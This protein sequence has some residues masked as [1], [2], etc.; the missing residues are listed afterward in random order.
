MSD[1]PSLMGVAWGGCAI[2]STFVAMRL[3]SRVIISRSM[4]WDDILVCVGAALNIVSVCLCTLAV[5][6]GLGR[7]ISSLSDHE[8]SMTLYYSTVLQP[9][10]VFSYC[11]PK[12][13]VVILI[14]KVMMLDRR[15]TYQL[16]ALI[17]LLFVTS[18]LA[19]LFLFV[20][21]DP[22]DHFWHPL[23][24]AHCMPA[25]VENSLTGIAGSEF[26]RDLFLTL[27]FIN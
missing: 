19:V 5:K 21:C 13:A 15:I 3:Y 16:C 18:F 23:R 4:G 26:S 24:E 2:S 7:H 1:G 12:L 10:A 27:A 6:Y 22:A 8:L 11:I 9:M 14:K 25:S 17:G 20:Q